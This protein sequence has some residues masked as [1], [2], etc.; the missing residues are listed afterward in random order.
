MDEGNL[1]EIPWESVDF[2]ADDST[3]PLSPT[4]PSSVS[5]RYSVQSASHSHLLPPFLTPKTIVCERR[6]EKERGGARLQL[7]IKVAFR[8]VV[9]SR[10]VCADPIGIHLHGLYFFLFRVFIS[11]VLLDGKLTVSKRKAFSWE[12]FLI[13]IRRGKG[14]PMKFEK[15]IS[16]L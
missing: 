2:A 5:S 1:E 13:P 16:P 7:L 9:S 11:F 15:G 14:I 6:R 8:S 12:Q 10:F 3:K 4:H